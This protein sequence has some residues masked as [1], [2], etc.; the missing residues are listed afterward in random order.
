MAEENKSASRGNEQGEQSQGSE[1]KPDQKQGAEKEN[2]SQRPDQ[3]PKKLQEK[4]PLYKRRGFI[5]IVVA[6]AVVLIVTPI[7]FHGRRLH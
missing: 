7:R 5:P 2:E 6:I 3:Q 1:R 4:P